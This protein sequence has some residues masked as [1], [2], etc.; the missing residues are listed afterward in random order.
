MEETDLNKVKERLLG[1]FANGNLKQAKGR[2]S[3]E[4]YVDAFLEKFKPKEPQIIQSTPEM[5]RILFSAFDFG[6][7]VKCEYCEEMVTPET[8][9]GFM[10]R[11]KGDTNKPIILCKSALCMASYF[12][13]ETDE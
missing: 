5:L 3:N 9:G 1:E 12:T 10:P 7:K 8:C 6:E 4:K 11:Y 13:Y 2:V